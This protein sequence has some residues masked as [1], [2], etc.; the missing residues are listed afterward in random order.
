MKEEARRAPPLLS[1]GAGGARGM[2]EAPFN[3]TSRSI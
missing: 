1:L 2:R 3:K